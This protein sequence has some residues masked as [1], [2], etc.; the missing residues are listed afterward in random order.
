M[1]AKLIF[2]LTQLLILAG[3]VGLVILFRRQHAD[4]KPGITEADMMRAREAI[5]KALG[6]ETLARPAELKPGQPLQVESALPQWPREM[7]AHMI[8]GVAENASPDAVDAAF[9]TL[10]KKYHPDRYA[11]WGKDYLAQAHAT[12]LRL[13]D[14][15]D[16]LR[17]KRP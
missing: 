14:A 2:Q 15:R 3:I 4:R 17:S 16:F 9:K 6:T 11:S 1:G 10:L 5:R 13:Q 7:P 12:V 8:L